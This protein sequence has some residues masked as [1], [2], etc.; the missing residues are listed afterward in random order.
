M[1]L[2]SGE[3][4]TGEE[5]IEHLNESD[6]IVILR[7]GGFIDEKSTYQVQS[8]YKDCSVHHRREHDV[9]EPNSKTGFLEIVDNEVEYRP[10]RDYEKR[11]VYILE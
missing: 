2:E 9:F 4:Y 5:I 8:G 6:D 7:Q 1:T 11:T 10:M 3:W